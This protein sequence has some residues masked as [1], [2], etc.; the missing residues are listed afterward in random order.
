MLRG[1]SGWW[2][3]VA[4]FEFRHPRRQV[5]DSALLCRLGRQH[6]ICVAVGTSGPSGEGTQLLIEADHLFTNA[7]HVA[8][9]RLKATVD[10]VE[11]TLYGVKAGLYPLDN[12][13]DQFGDGIE[14]PV[15]VRPKAFPL[16]VVQG[17]LSLDYV[18][19]AGASRPILYVSV[20]N[21]GTMPAARRKIH[22]E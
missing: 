18:T 3:A 8:L 6:G 9:Q 21:T 15:H 22:L 14:A 17:R 12:P 19:G 7:V 1:R 4:L 13:A 11:A 5:V 10:S 2:T 20:P 16:P